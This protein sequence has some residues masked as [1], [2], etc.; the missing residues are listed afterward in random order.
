MRFLTVSL[1]LLPV[2]LLTSCGT[3]RESLDYDPSQAVGMRS[4]GA[5]N[6]SVGGF[7]DA[8][9][10][11]SPTTLG[12][13]RTA[14]G[15][16]GTK[17]ETNIPVAQIVE[18]TFGYGIQLRGMEGKPGSS[19]WRISGIIKEFTCDQVIRA[20]AAA[21]ITVLLHKDNSDRASFRKT[22]HAEKTEATTKIGPM[23][24]TKFLKNIASDVLQQIV[25]RALDDPELR[26]ITDGR[27]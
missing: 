21:E 11:D 10:L 8:R 7:R 9:G 16:I 15:P 27:E 13:I 23:A 2:L 25:D 22:Y 1:F 17:I 18:N 4:G 12:Q 26:A 5:K 20:G 3:V 14:G 19:P 24:D 6:V